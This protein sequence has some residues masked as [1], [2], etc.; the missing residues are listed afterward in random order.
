MKLNEHPIP[1]NNF[2]YEKLYENFLEIKQDLTIRITEN[3]ALVSDLLLKE[4]QE[5]ISLVL[6]TFLKNIQIVWN[7]MAN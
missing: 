7:E 1:Y 5:I 4:E 3:C 2:F 6:M